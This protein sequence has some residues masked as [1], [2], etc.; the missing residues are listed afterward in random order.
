MCATCYGYKRR[1]LEVQD[2]ENIIGGCQ[3]GQ[4]LTNL[5]AV[6]GH[7]RDNGTFPYAFSS[8]YPQYKVRTLLS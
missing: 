7:L 1:T 3:A 8:E 2:M 6:R 5:V 4:F